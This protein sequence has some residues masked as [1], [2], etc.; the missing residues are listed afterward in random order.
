MTLE[1]N[2]AGSFD[3]DT[4]IG[5]FLAFADGSQLQRLWAPNNLIQIYVN[6]S[7]MPLSAWDMD[8]KLQ[9]AGAAG[10]LVI[11]ATYWAAALKHLDNVMQELQRLQREPQ[12]SW[13][14][15]RQYLASTR[16]DLR[17]LCTNL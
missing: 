11:L 3:D 9:K 4:T 2:G 1:V 17:Y 6:G 13:A 8:A 5:L 16:Q 7:T 15:A 12:G 14:L 10:S